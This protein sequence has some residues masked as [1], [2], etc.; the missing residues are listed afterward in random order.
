MILPLSIA[1]ALL[2]ALGTAA[3]LALFTAMAPWT[4]WLQ[5][6]KALGALGLYALIAALIATCVIYLSQELWAPTAR[7]TFELVRH[8]IPPHPEQDSNTSHASVPG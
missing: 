2:A 6:A 8:L 1:T 3:A 7:V 5:A 4:L